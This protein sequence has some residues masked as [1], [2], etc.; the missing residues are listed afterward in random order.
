MVVHWTNEQFWYMMHW[1]LSAQGPFRAWDGQGHIIY[2][3]SAIQSFWTGVLHGGW[4]GR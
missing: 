4:Y 3:G 1:L 2:G